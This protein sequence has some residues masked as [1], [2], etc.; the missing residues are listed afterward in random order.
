MGGVAILISNKRLSTKVTQ[1]IQESTFH[2]HQKKNLP[3]QYRDSEHLRSKHKGILIC[4]RNIA[5]A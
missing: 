4:K 2:T 1:N 5:K 3:G